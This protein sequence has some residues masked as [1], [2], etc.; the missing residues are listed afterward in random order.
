MLRTPASVRFDPYYKVQTWE[1]RV[2]AWQDIQRMFTDEDEARAA[3]PAGKRCRLMLVTM[4]GRSPLP[5]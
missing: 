2:M 4:N 5:E 1:R 3:F